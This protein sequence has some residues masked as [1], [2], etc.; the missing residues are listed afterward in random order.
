MTEHVQYCARHMWNVLTQGPCC[1]CMTSEERLAYVWGQMRVRQEI[2]Q[3]P[4]C[5]GT[6]AAGAKP[7]CKT[8]SHAIA[9]ILEREDRVKLVMEAANR[10]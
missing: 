2:L 9:A 1:Q 8:M 6:V 10:N 4:Y 5:L 3:C 7:C